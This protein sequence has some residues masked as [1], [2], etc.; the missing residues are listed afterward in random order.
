MEEV[1][2]IRV[3]MY[4]SE[5]YALGVLSDLRLQSRLV[6][7]SD[8][9]RA[10][11]KAQGALAMKRAAEGGSTI[12]GR[13]IAAQIVDKFRDR[14]MVVSD[15]VAIDRLTATRGIVW[16]VSPPPEVSVAG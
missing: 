3:Y 15:P 11:A 7:K 14:S 2:S 1:L 9:D 10:A 8:L 13:R 12:R 6:P 4:R 16:E 5:E